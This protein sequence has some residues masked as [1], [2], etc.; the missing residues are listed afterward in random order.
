MNEMWKF[1]EGWRGTSF[2]V[3]HMIYYLSMKTYELHEIYMY[4][5]TLSAIFNK[6]SDEAE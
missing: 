6:I 3:L 1:V 5:K 2:N 4:D